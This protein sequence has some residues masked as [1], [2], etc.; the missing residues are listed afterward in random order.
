MV[1]QTDVLICG[2]GSAG[3]CAAAWFAK[4]GIDF[5]IIDK[6][7]GPMERGQADGVQ[8]RTVEIFESFG[9]AEEL[10]RSSFHVIEVAFWALNEQKNLARINRTADSKPGLSH[11]PHVILNQAKLNGILLDYMHGESGRK[12]EYGYTVKQV[13]INNTS[14][15]TSNDDY[16][17][18]VIAEKDGADEVF[19]AKY[20]LGCDGAH[21][22][23]RKSLG[24]QMLGDT[25]DAIWGVMDIYPRTNFPDIRRKSTIHSAAGN[26]L[27]IPREGGSLVRFYIELPPGTLARNVT[28]AQLH[29]AARRI[30]TQFD[31]AVAE[32]YW[33]SA[34]AI[35]QRLV[36]HFSAEDRVFLTGDA[37]H[38][39][40]PKAGQGMNV[41]LQDGYNIGWKL[42][43]VLR[44]QVADP[45]ALLRTYDAERGRVARDLIEFDRGLM[46][47]FSSRGQDGPATSAAEFSEAFI[48]A[49]RYTAGMTALY[50]DSMVVA[51]GRS[52]Q[53]RAQGLVVG[54]RFPSAQV[55]RLCD[56]RA[57]QLGQALRSDGRWRIVV[58]AGEVGHEALERL[59]RLAEYL[60]GKDS[61]VK[62][63]TPREW[64]IDAFIEPIVVFS[65]RRLDLEQEQI[66][67]YFWP[68]TGKWK[69][70]DLHKI[71]V[72]DESYN[73][74]HGHAYEKYGID[75]KKGALAILRPDNYVAMVTDVD[76]HGGVLGFFEGFAVPQDTP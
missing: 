49:G 1:H 18:Q 74:G 10:L 35:G 57:M 47:L 3:L 69:M 24:Y 22:N 38:T 41:S 29:D 66:P 27:I 40:S 46:R 62:R 54:M 71:F 16:T 17:V 63:F 12:V 44:G 20:V 9:I 15:D 14:S 19:R 2:S 6:R 26:L 11:M 36:D 51:A 59:E 73:S 48:K 21:S 60:E 39:H 25:T 37:C 52:Q 64:D 45:A 56:A 31:L 75:T 5:T 68:E 30:F 55:V 34:Y 28:L 43:H 50:E 72:D 42:A 32:T 76:D 70:R 23:I 58:F 53:E 13:Q 4:C 8:C 65:G 67:P 33:W 7:L 61:P